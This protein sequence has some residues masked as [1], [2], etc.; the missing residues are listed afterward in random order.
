MGRMPRTQ[1]FC[2]VLGWLHGRGAELRTAIVLALT[3]GPD[4]ARA[5][6]QASLGVDA[7]GCCAYD[8]RAGSGH[9]EAKPVALMRSLKHLP[10][11][12]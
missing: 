3:L 2:L 12:C 4:P 5:R 10:I 1:V 9:D 8:A 11:H 6:V 7:F